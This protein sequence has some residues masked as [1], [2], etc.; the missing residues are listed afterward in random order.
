MKLCE[1]DDRLGIAG[2]VD[3]TVVPGGPQVDAATEYVVCYAN[4]CTRSDQGTRHG[5]G[6]SCRR[7]TVRCKHCTKGKK[8]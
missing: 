6:P 7:G 2:H 4:Q 3:G 5:D 1:A 8:R